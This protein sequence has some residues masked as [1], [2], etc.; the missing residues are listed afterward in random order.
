[1]FRLGL[2][3][4]AWSTGRKVAKHRLQLSSQERFAKLCKERAPQWVASGLTSEATDLFFWR[5]REIDRER[6]REIHIIPYIKIHKGFLWFSMVVLWGVDELL[7]FHSR[8]LMQ[9]CGLVFPVFFRFLSLS[10]G[11]V[12]FQAAANR[13]GFP[14]VST[15]PNPPSER[16]SG[17]LERLELRLMKSSKEA[18]ECELKALRLGVLTGGKTRV[19]AVKTCKN[20]LPNAKHLQNDEFEIN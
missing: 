3:F 7:I 5:D 2:F 15:R 14:V 9:A 4:L 20:H 6:E 19:K 17:G 18:R 12:L 1:M 11:G 8:D 13:W 10:S 16:P